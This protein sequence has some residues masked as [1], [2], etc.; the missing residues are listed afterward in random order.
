MDFG[1]KY[2]TIHP[3]FSAPGT[4]HPEVYATRA[5]DTDPASR[6]AIRSTGV[7]KDGTSFDMFLHLDAQSA[8]FRA[9]SFADRILDGKS[10]AD[11]MGLPRRFVPPYRPRGHEIGTLAGPRPSSSYEQTSD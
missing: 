2:I 5:L 9:N 6:L 8:V 4:R 1:N 11:I 3:E 7:R 10:V